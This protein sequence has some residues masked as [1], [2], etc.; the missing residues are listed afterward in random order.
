MDDL[1]IAKKVL[2][3][4]NG[5]EVFPA[6]LWGSNISDISLKDF[7]PCNNPSDAWPIILK[8]NIKIIPRPSEHIGSPKA[9]TW[10]PQEVCQPVLTNDELLRAAMIV[11]LK[12]RGVYDD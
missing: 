7:D 11:F 3:K 5:T 6:R 8:Y 10:G 9:C 1:E 2:R 4:I 12:L